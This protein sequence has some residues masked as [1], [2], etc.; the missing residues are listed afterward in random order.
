MKLWLDRWL[1]EFHLES[2]F[3]PSFH[4]ASDPNITVDKVLLINNRINL[5]FKRQ[6]IDNLVLD[7]IEFKKLLSHCLRT[8]TEDS[9]KWRWSS[10][11]SFSSN[12]LYI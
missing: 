4:I 1:G 5:N 2:M 7:W 9:I 6:L 10:S 8:R 11:G 12:S 3:P